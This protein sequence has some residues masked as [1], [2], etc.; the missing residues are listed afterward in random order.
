M[1]AVTDCVDFASTGSL[2]KSICF[3]LKE[4]RKL[5]YPPETVIGWIVEALEDRSKQ[6]SIINEFISHIRTVIILSEDL[7]CELVDSQFSIW[8]VS[9]W[10]QSQSYHC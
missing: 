2:H 9:L 7:S 10:S 6:P 1:D 4:A 5:G 3:S 8:P